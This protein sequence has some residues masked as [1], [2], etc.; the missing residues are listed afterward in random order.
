[1]FG[2][3]AS[4]TND[5]LLIFNIFNKIIQHCGKF[6]YLLSCTAVLQL[7]SIKQEQRHESTI[8]LII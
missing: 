8:K 6:N 1:M 5:V 2:A 3:S 7:F 4:V